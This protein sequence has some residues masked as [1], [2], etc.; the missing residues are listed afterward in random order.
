ME[1]LLYKFNFYILDGIYFIQL[2]VTYLHLLK[3]HH[4]NPSQLMC[5]KC[6]YIHLSYKHEI[7]TKPVPMI[8]KALTFQ[9]CSSLMYTGL[10]KEFNVPSCFATVSAA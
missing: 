5:K 9:G 6:I 2:L 10:R 1:Q 8:N 7:Y 3:T 4:L